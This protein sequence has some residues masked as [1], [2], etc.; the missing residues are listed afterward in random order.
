[1]AAETRKNTEQKHK[2]DRLKAEDAAA[3]KKIRAEAKAHA[4]FLK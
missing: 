1:M 2:M 4:K 3:I